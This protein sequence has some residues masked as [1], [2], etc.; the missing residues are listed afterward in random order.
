MTALL[1]LLAGAEV[2]APDVAGPLAVFPLHAPGAPPRYLSLAEGTARGLRVTEL[3]DGASVGDLLVA[4]PLDL[5]VLLYE[6]EE[7]VGAQQ[8]RTVDAAVLVPARCTLEVPVTCVERNRWDHRRHR[9]PFV[10]SA[11]TAH[12]SLRARKSARM[13]VAMAAGAVA[14]ADQGEVWAEVGP[15]AL[16]D[17]FAHRK[18]DLDR[19][20]AGVRPR[21]GQTGAIVAVG[22]TFAVADHVSR[23]EVWSDL[24]GPLMRGYALDAL[25]RGKPSPPPVAGE[26]REWLMSALSAPAERSPARGLGERLRFQTRIAGGTALSVEGHLVQA[27]VYAG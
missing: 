1:E 21:P 4:N 7:L 15:G 18:G 27:C 14:R 9:E 26:A 10:V 17:E 11:H 8:N 19:L 6:G 23:P 5:P 25:R 2:G 13:R 12:P 24:A 20:V 3:P 16:A 22:G